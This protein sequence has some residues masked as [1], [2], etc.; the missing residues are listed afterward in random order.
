MSE[1]KEA[2]QQVTLSFTNWEPYKNLSLPS[3]IRYIPP[4]EREDLREKLQKIK[5][6]SPED[7]HYLKIALGFLEKG[8]MED[9]FGKDDDARDEFCL[10]RKIKV[11]DEE[12]TLFELST[13]V[14]KLRGNAIV[15]LLSCAFLVF[16]ETPLINE[17]NKL[18]TKVEKIMKDR[19]Y[20]IK[21]D[22]KEIDDL[23][24]KIIRYIAQKY[25]AKIVENEGEN[26]N[27]LHQSQ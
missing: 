5:G 24:L 22:L 3:K 17:V 21:D 6:I 14:N 2:T 11:G 13:R 15:A 12:I 8:I 27:K 19:G 7:K 1:F 16:G 23:A 25:G 10:D 4:K 26:N 20:F 18:K 9:D